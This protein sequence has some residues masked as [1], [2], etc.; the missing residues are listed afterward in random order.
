M[1]YQPT[2]FRH[3]P[4]DR[5][6]SHEARETNKVSPRLTQLSA[7]RCSVDPGPER[8][9]SREA[10]VSSPNSG[11]R[12]QSLCKQRQLDMVDNSRVPE[13]WKLLR[14]GAP[15]LQG[16]RGMGWVTLEFSNENL[17][18]YV[19]QETLGEQRMTKE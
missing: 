12:Y 9:N 6:A 8:G 19:Q 10:S 5:I 2:G 15:R 11:D 3:Q 18:V 1:K 14:E 17:S 4:S 16:S 7:C 13:E